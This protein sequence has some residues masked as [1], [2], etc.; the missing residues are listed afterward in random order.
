[1]NSSHFKFFFYLK[2]MGCT[3][4][5]FQFLSYFLCRPQL[6]AHC[7]LVVIAIMFPKEFTPEAHVALDKFLAALALALSEKYR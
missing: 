4:L 7:M 3:T 5:A 2:E 1:M 6:L